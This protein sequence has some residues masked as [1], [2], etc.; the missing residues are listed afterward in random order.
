MPRRAPRGHCPAWTN[1]LG[2]R[3]ELIN[4]DVELCR[5]GHRNPRCAAVGRATEETTGGVTVHGS[6]KTGRTGATPHA[7]SPRRP[8]PA[9]DGPRTG[10]RLGRY[11]AAGVRPGER[12][13][14]GRAGGSPRDRAAA[15]REPAGRADRDHRVERRLPARTERHRA[16]GSRDPRAR[17]GRVHGRDQHQRADRGAARPAALGS[18]HDRGPRRAA[19]FRRSRADTDAGHEP[20]DVRPRERAGAEGSA[21]HAVR[22]QQHRRR[23]AAD[24]AAPRRRIRRLRRSAAR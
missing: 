17:D 16:G 19:V 10:R 11:R 6:K 9:L 22:P 18:D 23:D 1:R 7:R 14:H 4:N 24:A 15:R 20:R 21:G 8:A 2:S 5:R 13:A 12:K 3:P